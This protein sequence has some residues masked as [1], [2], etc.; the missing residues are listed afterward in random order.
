MVLPEDSEREGLERE[1]GRER[2][3]EGVYR[4]RERRAGRERGEHAHHPPSR[5][6]PHPSCTSSS[7]TCCHLNQPQ[8]A[9]ASLQVAK[10]L[11]R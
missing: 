5:W 4:E 8:A 11:T 9:R 6:R 2:V 3:R 1:G 10:H 7:L